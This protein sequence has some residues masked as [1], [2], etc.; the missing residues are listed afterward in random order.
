MDHYGTMSHRHAGTISAAGVRE[1]VKEPICGMMVDKA[2]ALTSG[3]GG[4]TD[5]FRS[6]TCQRT[7]D[8]PERGLKSM[9]AVALTGVLP[10]RLVCRRA[11]RAAVQFLRGTDA[12]RWPWQAERSGNCKGSRVAAS[13]TVR[14]LVRP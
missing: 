10:A 12:M 8:D 5:Y 3:R 6:A 4:R 14:A 1:L 9:R 2:T 7:F 13:I 11:V